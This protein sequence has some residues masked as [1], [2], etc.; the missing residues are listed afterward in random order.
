[1][2]PR[3]W[4]L[5]GALIFACS[6]AGA[7]CAGAPAASAAPA[8][9]PS[10]A[11]AAKPT[12]SSDPRAWPT[13]YEPVTL[14]VKEL[15]AEAKRYDGSPPDAQKTLRAEATFRDGGV[16][17]TRREVWLGENYRT[18]ST[19]GPFVTAEGRNDGQLWETNEN[20]Y[21]LL[22]RGI[23]KRA[24]ANARALENPNPGDELQLLG[25]LRAPANVYVLR[26]APPDGRDERRFYDAKTYALVRR[27]TSYLGHLVVTTYD[28]FRTVNGV[29]LAFR[30]TVSDGHTENDY[31]QTITKLQIGVPVAD[32]EVA[33]PGSRRL[34]VKLP[35][36][37]S[38]VRLPARIDPYGRII[39]RVTVNG[40]GLD[41]QLDSG[42]SGIVLDRDVARQLGVA[43]SGRWSNTVAGTF[44]STNAILP[45]AQV[46]PITMSDLVVEALPFNYQND[47][48]T[49][50]V[51]L[52]GFDFIAGAVLK[53]DYA[54]GTVDAI[55]SEKF[56]PPENGVVLDAI[57]DDNVPMITMKMNDAL[58]SHFI[59][60]TGADMV[61]A[62]SGF[63]KRYPD[64]VDDHSEHKIVSRILNVVGVQGVGGKLAM[65]G[66]VLKSM[67]LGNVHYHDFLALV[68]LGDQDEFEGEDADGLAGIPLLRSFDVY[69]DYASS[70]VVLVPNKYT[71]KITSDKP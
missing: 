60:D 54:N 40:R 33:I 62:F 26:V 12:G 68:L 51:G 49:K 57:L 70:R 31:V 34:P 63:A 71:K 32:E 41:F 45:S 6:L 52:L 15:L 17:G 35:D 64:A 55:P 37:V 50:V 39:V 58:G 4:R 69:L 56:A 8:P 24:D 42:A 66:T 36:G 30:R 27:E 25:R 46:G 43:T 9:A 67:Q 48:D 19:L 10:A 29:T 53:I 3:A 23:H 20:G 1:M 21:T 16:T 14:T 11:P 38:S 61:I 47:W 59:L 5:S 65:H 2:R 7:L 13:T 22:K 28:D 44:V 18:D